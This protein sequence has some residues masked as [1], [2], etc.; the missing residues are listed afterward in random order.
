MEDNEVHPADGDGQQDDTP[1]HQAAGLKPVG[2]RGDPYSEAQNQDKPTHRKPNALDPFFWDFKFSVIAQLVLTFILVAVGVFQVCIYMQ[3]ARIMS[4]QSGIIGKQADIARTQRDDNVAVQRAFVNVSSLRV[5]HGHL[6]GM[7][8]SDAW[9]SFYPDITNDGNTPTVNMTYVA[10]VEY[11]VAA[12]LP[13]KTARAPVETRE[14]TLG[15]GAVI[16]PFAG[17]LFPVD[18][19]TLHDLKPKSPVPHS[20]FLGPHGGSSEISGVSL[21][22][23]V[24]KW[25]VEN[26]WNPYI[27]GEARYRDVFNHAIEHVTKYC[28]MIYAEATAKGFRPRGAY[29]DYWNCADDECTENKIRYYKD[30]DEYK[31][32]GKPMPQ[33][34]L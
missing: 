13:G 8:G 7:K 31:A 27:Y 23:E 9:W 5:E 12:P 28:F 24:L 19:A 10:G 32:S 22:E 16:G 34:P 11:S 26:G 33:P 14:T 29:C 4:D 2:E 15:V 20:I 25:D 30:L 1:N 18:P 3:Q 6:G 21:P 17:K